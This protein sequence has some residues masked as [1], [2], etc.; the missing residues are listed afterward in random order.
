MTYG[1]GNADQV[2]GTSSGARAGADAAFHALAQAVHRAAER[3]Q[4]QFS[5]SR[6]AA[7]AF[8]GAVVDP[9]E[10]RKAA[11][12]PERLYVPGGALLGLRTRVWTRRVL[13]DP[14]NPRIGPARRHP[15]AVQPGSTEDARFRPVP[16]PVAD[17]ED[18]PELHLQVDSREHLS[19]ASAIA[20]KYIL[21]DNDWRL[22]IRN[23][24]I[25]TEVWLSAMT[26]VHGDGTSS[27]TVPVTSEGSSRVTACHDILSVRSAD[28]QATVRD[29]P[30]TPARRFLAESRVDGDV[31]CR[32]AV[33]RCAA[34]C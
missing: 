15:A 8:A 10:I 16:D 12:N 3:L 24:G 9:A 19:W 18:R 5:L 26:L 6:V 33:A 25:M 11:D 2:A 4:D 20:K 23:Q 21:K 7:E 28:V 34:A 31:R 27:V 30:G 29:D 1:G 17:P 13:P 32:G 14:R 22:S